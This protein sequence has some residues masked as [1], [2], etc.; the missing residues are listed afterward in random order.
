[1]RHLIILALL[2]GACGKKSSSE[3]DPELWRHIPPGEPEF[4]EGFEYRCEDG[5]VCWQMTRTEVLGLVRPPDEK[6]G[7]EE[8]KWIWHETRATADVCDPTRFPGT[9][10]GDH[11]ECYLV[12]TDWVVSIM[13]KVK[14]VLKEGE[15]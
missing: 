10:E 2:L 3:P 14:Y 11:L 9:W 4:E 8:S 15:E 13:S 7:V 1:M 6:G 12:F 5:W